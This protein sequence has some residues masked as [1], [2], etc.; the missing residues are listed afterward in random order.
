MANYCRAGI[1]SL[2]GTTANTQFS[3]TM[4]LFVIDVQQ[5]DNKT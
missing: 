2:R 1:K 3:E 5:D 4:H